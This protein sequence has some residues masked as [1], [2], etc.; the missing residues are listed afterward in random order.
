MKHRLLALVALAVGGLLFVYTVVA[1]RAFVHDDVYVTLRYAR[2][3]LAGNGLVWNVGERVEGYSS[4]LHVLLIAGG[5]LAGFDLLTAARAVNFISVIALACYVA[6]FVWR[7][8]PTSQSAVVAAV[9]ALLILGSSP[10]AIWVCGGLEAPMFALVSTVAVG[11][12][13]AFLEQPLSQRRAL[14]AGLALGLTMLTRPEGALFLLLGGVLSLGAL[15]RHKGSCIRPFATYGIAAV[16]LPGAHLAWRLAYYGT[17]APNAVFAKAFGL[18]PG[19]AQTGVRYLL[20]L[21]TAPPFL[22]PIA[23]AAAVYGLRG[24]AASTVLWTLLTACLSYAAMISWIGGDHMPAHRLLLPLIPLSALAL[25]FGIAP[26]VHGVGWKPMGLVL[27]ALGLLLSLQLRREPLRKDPAAFIGTIVGNHIADTWPAGTLIASNN[28]GSL[29]YF[30]DRYRY[31]DMLGLNDAH[32]GR[33][34]ISRVRLRSQRAPGHAKGDGRYVLARNP[35]IVILGPPEGTYLSRPWFLSDLELAESPSFHDRYQVRVHQID[36][37][38]VP[39]YRDHSAAR[40]GMVRFI[41]YE[42]SP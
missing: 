19:T 34:K 35:K 10:L 38:K 42:R 11:S 16:L 17:W 26:L 33:R 8:Q 22:V 9:P 21:V 4:F 20:Q 13:I 40:T 27:V 24:K 41:Y 2:N 18:P 5:G 14:I 15:R 23:I 28:A 12:L 7:R 31:I 30:A 37:R 6:V 32:I 3:L 36:V 1:N 39:G 25:S 29:P